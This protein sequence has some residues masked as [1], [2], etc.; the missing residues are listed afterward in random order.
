MSSVLISVSWFNSEFTGNYVAVVQEGVSVREVSLRCR[1]VIKYSSIFSWRLLRLACIG[2]QA[3]DCFPTKLEGIFC[4]LSKSV[5][6]LCYTSGPQRYLE[7]TGLMCLGLELLVPS[8]FPQSSNSGYSFWVRHLNFCFPFPTV[9]FT[10]LF[11]CAPPPQFVLPSWPWTLSGSPVSGSW[12]Y[13]P[14][15]A[16]PP[17]F[18]VSFLLLL[19]LKKENCLFSFY[20]AIP[21]PTLFP[22]P[23]PSTW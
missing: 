22:P 1:C 7:P 8:G 14:N 6:T 9:L 3:G 20:I 11:L 5:L 15:L 12:D 13:C 18:N 21:V 19:F 23:I 4:S 17:V 10:Y 2:F 16:F